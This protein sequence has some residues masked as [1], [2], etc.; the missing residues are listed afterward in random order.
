MT[1]NDTLFSAADSADL[2]ALARALY[3]HDGL[4]D[5][6]Y[7]RTVASIEGRASAE[8][9]L[10]HTL[11]DGLVE[12]R[13]AADGAPA[14]TDAATLQQL[15]R[16]REG[17][18]FFRAIRQLTAWYFYDDHEV[19]AFVGYPGPSFSLGGYL[20]RGFNDLAWLPE[21]RIEESGLDLPEIGPLD[22]ANPTVKAAS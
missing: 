22:S 9:A 8:P 20:H 14:S 5:A 18:P 11:N 1:S 19:W 21:P 2:V 12:L 15:L 4:P 17:T 10:W 6:P 7:L 3:P 16:D 13:G